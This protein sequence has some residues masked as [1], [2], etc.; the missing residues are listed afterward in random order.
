MVIRP[1]NA[2]LGI[3]EGDQILPFS[4]MIHNEGD[5]TLVIEEVAVTCGC[6]M[7][8]LPDS[9]VEPG[10]AVPLKGSFNT[11]KME[12][13]IHKAI[14]LFSNDPARK[15]GVL[16]ID[17]FIVREVSFYPPQVFFSN[18]RVNEGMTKTVTIRSGTDVPLE[19]DSVHTMTDLFRIEVKSLERTGD[20]EL[21][22]HLL[23]QEKGGV[24]R[25]TITVE[26]NVEGYEEI[27]IPIL[28]QIRR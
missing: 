4:L 14:I 13:E 6:T 22:L 3:V 16:T 20:Y 21:D 2:D 12:G 11:R 19:I 5:S 17:G 23:P 26:T 28:G 27:R 1:P 8:I 10:E 18:A 9:T 7:A 25:D 15:K 24:M